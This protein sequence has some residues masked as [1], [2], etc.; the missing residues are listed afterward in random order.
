MTKYIFIQA[1][2]I[3]IIFYEIMVINNY[4]YFSLQINMLGTK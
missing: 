2:K 3:M 4:Y 1:L